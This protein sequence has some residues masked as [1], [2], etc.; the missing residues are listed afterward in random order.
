MRSTRGT[1]ERGS[2]ARPSASD[3][4]DDQTGQPVMRISWDDATAY[5]DWRGG[6][7]PSSEAPSATAPL[8]IG[9]WRDAGRRTTRTSVILPRRACS[10][11][12]GEQYEGV[13]RFGQLRGSLAAVD[14]YPASDSPEGVRQLCGNVAEWVIGPNGSFKMRGGSYRMPGELWALLLCSAPAQDDHVHRISDF[15]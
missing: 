14:E 12:W 13:Q 10:H 1:C 5:C 4:A 3:F 8:G 7:L 2:I 11:P 15:V 6:A 9:E